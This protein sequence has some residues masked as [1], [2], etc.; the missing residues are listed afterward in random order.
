M[1]V[2]SGSY[3]TRGPHILPLVM[4]INRTGGRQRSQPRV[5]KPAGDVYFFHSVPEKSNE[6]IYA[7]LHYKN[8]MYSNYIFEEFRSYCDQQ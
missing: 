3:N 2:S 4:F 5:S 7:L 8:T 1:L 6:F